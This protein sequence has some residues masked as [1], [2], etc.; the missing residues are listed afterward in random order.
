MAVAVLAVALM[1]AARGGGLAQW[2]AQRT[3][4]AVGL[5]IGIGDPLY[6]LDPRDDRALA[7][8]ATD[9]VL[10]RVLRQTGAKGAPTS[11]PGQEL[12]QSQ[13]AVEVLDVLKGR[14]G[15]VVTVN[16]IGGLDSQAGGVM[17]LEGDELLRPGASELFLL[18]YV[19]ERAWYQVVAG[20]YGHLPAGDASQR[21]ALLAR[22]AGAIG[23]QAA[24]DR[25]R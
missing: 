17:L 14:A 18:V 24:L 8:Y 13:F 11:A 12:P 3:S 21:E 20:G 5:S 10:G 23:D 7:A 22:F 25:A 1:L 19:P 16:Q 4:A 6:E 15:G 2:H 9:I